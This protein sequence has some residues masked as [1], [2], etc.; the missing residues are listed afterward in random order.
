MSRSGSR[1]EFIKQTAFAMGALSTAASSF[2]TAS[3]AD[4][5]T[6]PPQ[7]DISVWSTNDRERFAAGE[8]I[9]W[10]PASETPSPDSVRLVT[11]NQ[12]QDILGFG[13]CFSDA[14][15]FQISQLGPERRE[16]FLHDLFHPSEM[17]L[18][19]NRTCIGAADSAAEVY[20]YDEGEPR[21]R[22]EALLYRA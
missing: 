9:A 17:N 21:S 2:G 11:G 4:A 10:H 16:E 14:A 20:S 19:V 12:F 22:V 18:N 13:G 15:C 5:N 3:A 1:R 7:S 8:K 6:L